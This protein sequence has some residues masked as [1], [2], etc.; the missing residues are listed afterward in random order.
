MAEKQTLETLLN[1]DSFIRWLSNKS[2]EEEQAYW[3][4][5][6]SRDP[7]RKELVE[8]ARELTG[9]AE[10]DEPII[11]EPEK[12]LERLM[13]ALE[14]KES[15]TGRKAQPQTRGYYRLKPFWGSVAAGILMLITILGVWVNEQNNNTISSEK[16]SV[17]Q[18]KQEFETGNGEK[19]YLTLS[20]GSTIILNANSK[21]K[22]L[23]TVKKGQDIGVRL[24]GEAYFDIAHY[25]GKDQRS[26]TVYTSDGT[27]EVLGTEFA[28]KTASEGTRAVL[29][30]GKIQVIVDSDRAH[31]KKK[32]NVVLV[33]GELAQFNS[34]LDEI[35][36]SKVNTRVYT[37]WINDTWVFDET[38]LRQVA[39]RLEDTFGVEVEI[40]TA[41]KPKILSGSIK[42]TDLN[43]LQKALSEVINEPV[44]KKGNTIF[45]GEK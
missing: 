45:I 6:L 41:L 42:S 14:K 24:Q 4:E 10:L 5:W 23:S 32:T 36:R 1:D 31:N 21:L 34:K 25:E 11:S 27:V 18:K 29:E 22:Y 33:P 9:V 35:E 44:T 30:K 40:A 2:S 8:Q 43:F 15:H 17:T 13:A 28:V 12:E 7:A 26:F 38:P 3:Q 19:K 16:T 20:D 37:S 39:D